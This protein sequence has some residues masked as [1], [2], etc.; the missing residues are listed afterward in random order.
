MENEM[1]IEQQVAQLTP[2]QRDTIIKIDKTTTIITVIILSVWGLWL[3][4]GA[5]LLINPPL[6]VQMD[7]G[8]YSAGVMV[9]SL[10]AAACFFGTALF[11]KAKFPFYSDKKLAYIKKQRKG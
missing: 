8:V 2:Q 10:I 11:V 1:T 5:Y 3:L 9:A 6:G 7:F 4:L